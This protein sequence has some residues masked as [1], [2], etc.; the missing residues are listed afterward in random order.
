MMKNLLNNIRIVLVEPSHNGNIGSTAR[1]MLNMG[2]TD[3]WLVNPQNEIDDIA[4]T[5]SCHAIDVVK[6]AKIVDSLTDA[7]DGVDFVVGTSAR[8]RRVS[9]P[10]EPISTVATTIIN[11]ISEKDQKIA[12]LFGRERIGLLNEELLMSN[13]HAFI[14]SNEG[15]TSLNLAQAVQL[16]A[17]EIFKQNLEY[18]NSKQVPEYSQV[19]ENATA[20]ERL[21]L[22]KHFEDEMIKSGFLDKD[23]PGYVLDKL[24]RLFQRNELETHEV[25]ILRGFLSSINGKNKS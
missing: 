23:N 11:R 13:I 21:G 16:V 10:I 5:L 15:Y 22:Y 25:N 7:L 8:V 6:N 14:P 19:H 17:Y 4:L 24:K 1:A 18:T 3:L 9:L 2:L 12:I 20:N